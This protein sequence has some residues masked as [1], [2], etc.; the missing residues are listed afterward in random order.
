M[1]EISPREYGQLESEVR[2]L[3]KTVESMQADIKVM[4]DLLEQGRGGWR[5]LVWLGGAAATLSA[6]ISWLVTHWPTK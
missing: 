2:H 6:G 5:T 3:Q 4:R 1:N